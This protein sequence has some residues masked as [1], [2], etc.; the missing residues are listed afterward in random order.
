[1][2]TILT[3]SIILGRGENT[4]EVFMRRSLRARRVSV[5]ISGHKGVE[6][7]IPKNMSIDRATKFLYSREAWVL[8]QSKW[9]PKIE[10]IPFIEGAQIPICGQKYTITHSGS[11]RGITRL[12]DDRLIIAGATES[13]T[14]KTKIFLK[15]MAQK[16]IEAY[17]AGFAQKLGIK[18]SRI[19]LRD[20][21][22]RWG[23]CSHNKTLSFSWRLIMAPN[24][25][26]EYVV[27]HEVAHLLEMNHSDK[28]WK[29]VGSIC[30]DY[31]IRRKWLRDNGANLHVYG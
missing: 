8:S 29:V 22:S 24:D 17:S 9:V 12:E 18:Y 31:K 30:P 13:L 28:F 2:T 11:L 19:T 14:R 5:R 20:T 16:E 1:M 4:V 26:L 7:V 23:S 6:L 15:S 27:A 25:V 10:Q 21:T 3:N